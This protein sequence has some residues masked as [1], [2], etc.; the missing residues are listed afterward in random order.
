MLLK[1]K[2]GLIT[3]VANEKSIAWAIAKMASEH[4]AEIAL[5][6]Q[7][8][9]LCKRVHPLADQIGCDKLYH[10]DF[11]NQESVDRMFAHL[12][13]EWGRLDFVL[14]SIVFAHKEDL[15]GRYL[16]TTL[17]HFND[18]LAISCYSMNTL[19]RGVEKLMTNGGSIVTLTYHGARK[20]VPSYNI[21]GVAKAAL[22]ASV[23]YI[24][25]EVGKNGIRVNSISAGPIKTLAS[26]AVRGMSHMLKKI[27]QVA[28]L[29]R[30][31][32]GDDVAGA[33]LY[34]FSDLASGVTGENHYVDAGY[35]ILGFLDAMEEIN[36]VQT[37]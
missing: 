37:E 18:C 4:G 16:D 22:E 33:A 27:P 29:R 30:N 23:R 13:K 20:V 15:M 19:V 3:G 5:S 21:M 1:G 32:T 34:L 2:R 11:S 9:A 36:N 14:H 31:I 26:S 6:Y 24:A 25:S 8:E 10:V 35:N 17:E 7:G 28:P 12:E